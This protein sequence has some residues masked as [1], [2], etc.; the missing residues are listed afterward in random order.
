MLKLAEQYAILSEAE[1]SLTVVRV[2]THA[3]HIGVTVLRREGD[4]AI[5][6]EK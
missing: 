1:R 4:I 3:Y 2:L 6:V 5:V